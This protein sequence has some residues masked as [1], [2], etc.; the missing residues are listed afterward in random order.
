[1]AARRPARARGVRWD[2]RARGA[3]AR[4]LGQRRAPARPDRRR[5]RRLHVAPAGHVAAR[6]AGGIRGRHVGQRGA[7]GPRLPGGATGRA[8]DRAVPAGGEPQRRPAVDAPDHGDRRRHVLR[9]HPGVRPR[10]RAAAGDSGRGRRARVGPG[11][12]RRRAHAPCGDRRSRSSSSARSRPSGTRSRIA[13]SR[14]RRSAP[15]SHA[16]CTTL[17]HTRST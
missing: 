8:D 13:A 7:D 16:T 14:S 9:A 17:R 11:V 15:G 4:K 12:V 10:P 3:R 6:A 2:H 5:A 1:M